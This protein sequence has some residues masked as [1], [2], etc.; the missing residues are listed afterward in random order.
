LWRVQAYDPQC[1]ER[2]IGTDAT[3]PGAL[4]AAWI[5]SHDEVAERL[6]QFEFVGLHMRDFDCVPR[7]VP[8]HWTFEIDGMPTAGRG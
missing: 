1:N 6:M 8:D 7:H 5:L 4:A 2:G 3:L